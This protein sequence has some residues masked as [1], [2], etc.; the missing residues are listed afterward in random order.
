MTSFSVFKLT[1]SNRNKIIAMYS[2]HD[3][4]TDTVIYV[5]NI[6]CFY[7]KSGSHTVHILC[8]ISKFRESFIRTLFAQFYVRVWYFTHI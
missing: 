6:L 1:V 7:I 4:T 3:R 2:T 5:V 8:I